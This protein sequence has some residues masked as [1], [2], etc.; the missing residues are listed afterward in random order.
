MKF[1]GFA[2][3]HCHISG[4]E[5]TGMKAMNTIQINSKITLLYLIIP[6][7]NVNSWLELYLSQSCLILCASLHNLCKRAQVM[8]E[9]SRKLNWVFSQT[10]YGINEAKDRINIYLWF[11]KTSFICIFKA[12]L[13]WHELLLINSTNLFQSDSKHLQLCW[14]TFRLDKVF[15]CACFIF[16]Y[17]CV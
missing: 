6:Q 16:Q 12:V 9:R 10:W 14:N 1:L 11:G 13:I 17:L 8:T 5:N 3:L 7:V 4:L 2:D 15:I